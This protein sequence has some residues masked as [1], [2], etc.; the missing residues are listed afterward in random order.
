MTR[1]F[2]GLRNCANPSNMNEPPSAIDSTRCPVCDI[3]LPFS[4]AMHMLAAHSPNATKNSS[5]TPGVN[6]RY[7]HI[8]AYQQS[9]PNSASDSRRANHTQSA[10]SKFVK[11]P[12]KKTR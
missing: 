4:L 12:G 2:A 7:L 3:K 11:R 6:F 9:Q 5:E 10:K 1:I 8:S